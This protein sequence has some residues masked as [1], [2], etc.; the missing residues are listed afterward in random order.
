MKKLIAFLLILVACYAYSSSLAL[1]LGY[2]SKVA[3]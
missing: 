3:Y 1:E 2:L